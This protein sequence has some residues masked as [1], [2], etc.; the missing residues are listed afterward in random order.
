MR[1]FFELTGWAGAGLLLAAYYL[2]NIRHSQTVVPKY[3]N[4]FGSFFLVASAL[5]TRTYPFV[6]LNFVW[7]VIAV[8]VII[9]SK[10]EGM[11]I[12]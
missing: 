5:Y 2:Q 1:L 4:V 12:R 9:L 6:V 7:M 8:R 11:R 10:K 3:L